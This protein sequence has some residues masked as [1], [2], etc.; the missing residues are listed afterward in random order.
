MKAAAAFLSILIL[1]CLA[2]YSHAST[3]SLL[4]IDSAEGSP[5]KELREAMI[6]ELETLGYIKGKNLSITYWSLGNKNGLAERAWRE[7][8][9]KTYDVV[10]LNGTVAALNFYNYIYDDPAYNVVFGAVTDPVSIGIIDNFEDLPKGNFTGICYP[11]QLKD[12]LRFIMATMPD[13]KDI[14]YIYSD[15]PQSHS[16]NKWLKEILAAP[17]FSHLRFHFRKVP[18]VR[19]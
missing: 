3:A 16:Y 2:A 7:E 11:V 1:S 10:F 6:A 5:Y 19:R 13:A 12:R 8:K 17:E 18:F 9:N 15:M 14:G 4:I